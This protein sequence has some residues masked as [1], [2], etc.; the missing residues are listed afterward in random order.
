VPV[1][2][3]GLNRLTLLRGRRGETALR[4]IV[5]L[6]RS[7]VLIG[8]GSLVSP[9]NRVPANTEASRPIAR[10]RIPGICL[11]ETVEAG[12]RRGLP[13]LA[14]CWVSASVEII[15]AML[16]LNGCALA[17]VAVKEMLVTESAARNRA[18]ADLPVCRME[19]LT[20]RRH[21]VCARHHTGLTERTRVDSRLLHGHAAM[22]EFIASHGTE[23]VT[24]MFV[25]ERS[26][27]V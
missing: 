27:H 19:A 14:T 18:G 23:S 25:G 1:R 17:S 3:G 10:I 13:R 9:P 5:R 26:I 21:G 6:R 15:C 11:S 24:H 16:G 12:P 8:G 7:G 22:A 4:L 20:R 2:S